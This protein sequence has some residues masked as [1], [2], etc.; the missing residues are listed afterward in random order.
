MNMKLEKRH[1]EKL[2][3]L[4]NCYEKGDMDQKEV[5]DLLN[6]E[7][8]LE[9]AKPDAEANDAWL[10]ACGEFWSRLLKRPQQR[11]KAKGTH[12]GKNLFLC[13]TA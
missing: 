13:Y 3:E 11:H 2:E 1:I 7:I 4:R 9:L 6:I 5:A 12:G 8:M 10:Q